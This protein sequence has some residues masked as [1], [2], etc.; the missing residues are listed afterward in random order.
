MSNMLLTE[1]A[2]GG[3]GVAPLVLPRGEGL[4]TVSSAISSMLRTGDLGV[5]GDEARPEPVE[6]A[7]PLLRT[8]GLPSNS[9]RTSFRSSSNIDSNDIWFAMVA[10]ADYFV[11]SVSSWQVLLCSLGDWAMMMPRRVLICRIYAGQTLW[12]KLLLSVDKL[13][14]KTGQFEILHC[15]WRGGRRRNQL[16]SWQHPRWCL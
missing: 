11:I 10:V 7:D 4:G 3:A 15:G 8:P 12:K 5:N 13:S 9:A 1:P 16:R 6:L 14:W 2:R